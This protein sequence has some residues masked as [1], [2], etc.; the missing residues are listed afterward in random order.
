LRRE[1]E[2]W[3]DATVIRTDTTV[4]RSV[5]EALEAVRKPHLVVRP[6]G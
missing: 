5:A 4:D 2:P 1:A 6:D 3:P